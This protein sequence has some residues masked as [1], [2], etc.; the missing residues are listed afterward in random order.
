MDAMLPKCR[1]ASSTSSRSLGNVG[2]PSRAARKAWRDQGEG[3]DSNIN[4]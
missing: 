2:K 4:F 3:L 1:D